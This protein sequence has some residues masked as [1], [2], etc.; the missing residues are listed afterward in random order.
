MTVADEAE[1]GAVLDGLKQA[2]SQL[3]DPKLSPTIKQMIATDAIK[4]V[5]WLREK[6]LP[7]RKPSGTHMAQVIR[8]VKR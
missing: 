2:A 1:I 4:E 6:V 5:E 8:L 3:L 7:R